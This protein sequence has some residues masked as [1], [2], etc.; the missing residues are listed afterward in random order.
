MTRRQVAGE[1][2]ADDTNNTVAVGV[3]SGA[4]VDVLVGRGLVKRY[5]ELVV[6]DGVD[7]TVG[8]AEAVGIV[9]P[10]GAGKTTLLSVLAG[11][12]EP[13]AG[14]VR[15]RGQVVTNLRPDL[16]CRRGLARAFQVP[17]PFGGMTVLENVLVGATAGG[18][19][20]GARAYDRCIEALVTCGLD[21]LSNRRADSLGLLHRK[22]L[23]LARAL[24]TEP[25]VVLLDEIGGG[26]TDAEA[27]ELVLTIQQ[28]HAQGVAIVWIEHIVHILVQVVDR[29]VCMD[30]GRVIADGP[31]ETVLQD[32]AVVSAYLG[33]GPE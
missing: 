6:L 9:G 24:A 18:H 3:G 14:D 5:G 25:A 15:L 2:W 13:T 16:R 10:N 19:L 22:R 31:P 12:V 8:A 27:A 28:L 26:L 7:F 20:R 29:L 32:A 33:R 1:S 17:R 23:E 21:G 4:G 11:S 30:A